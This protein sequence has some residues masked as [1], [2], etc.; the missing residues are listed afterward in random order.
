MSEGILVLCESVNGN[1]IELRNLVG[2]I[3]SRK[4]GWYRHR[5]VDW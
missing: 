5:I 4:Y 2:Q 3:S 1:Q